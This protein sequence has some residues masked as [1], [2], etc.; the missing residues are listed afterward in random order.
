MSGFKHV[1]V[2][3]IPKFSVTWQDSEYPSGCNYGRVLNIP[4]FQVFQVSAYA[5]VAHGSEYGWIMPYGRVLNMHCQ[6]LIGF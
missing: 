3:N 1:R 4:G 5:S 2:L 6:R